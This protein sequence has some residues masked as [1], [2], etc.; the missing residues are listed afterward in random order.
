MQ[1][2]PMSLG[3]IPCWYSQTLNL[4]GMPEPASYVATLHRA[5]AVDE[6]S[7]P[8]RWAGKAEESDPSYIF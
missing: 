4:P 8:A 1:D 5:P 6:L 7:F 2:L 3:T